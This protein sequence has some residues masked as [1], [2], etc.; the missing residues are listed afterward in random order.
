MSCI[1]GYLKGPVDD[2][3]LLGTLRLVK[4]SRES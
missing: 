2:E 4:T 3:E 1:P